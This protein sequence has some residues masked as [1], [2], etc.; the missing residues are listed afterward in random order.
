MLWED[1]AA[2]RHPSDGGGRAW[3][4]SVIPDEGP[5]AL[6]AGGRARFELVYQAGPLG[7]LEGGAVFLQTSP[8]WGWDTPQTAFPDAP[9]YTTVQSDAPGIELEAYTLAS[10]LLGIFV[11]G[12]KLEAGEQI[13]ITFGA[14][15]AMAQVDR[16]AEREARIWFAVDGDGDGVRRLVEDSPRIDIATAAP[17]RLLLTL[18]STVR[19]GEPFRLSVAVTDWV[20]NADIPFEGEVRLEMPEG[21]ELP[22]VIELRPEDAGSRSVEGVVRSEGIFA[23]VGRSG[24]LSAESNPMLASASAPRILWADLHGHSQLSDGTGTPEDYFR[25]ARDVAALDVVALTDH[26]HWGIRFLDE[27]PDLWEQIRSTAQRF[28][29]PGR[30]VTLLGYEWTSWVH[31]HRH[32]LYFRD[33]GEVFSTMDPDTATPA[34]LW[35][36][37]AGRPA[38]TFA[39]HSAG[40]PIGT[41]WAYRPD[42]EIE[43]VTEVISVH[44]SSEAMD[45][46]D[47]IY[48]PVEGNFVRDVLDAGLRFGFIGSGDSHDGHPGLSQL[49][50]GRGGLAAIFSEDATR[51]GVL[52]ALRAR[53]CYATN[54]PRIWLRFAL[55]GRPMGS[56]LSVTSSPTQE[57]DVVAIATAPIE[58]IDLVRSGAEVESLEGEGRRVWSEQIE[59]PRLE[60]GEYLYLRVLQEDGGAAWSSPIYA[61]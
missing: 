56:M 24:D 3:I 50:S 34:G 31:G 49:A 21:V 58:R 33:E 40:G 41:D 10:Q 7:V 6:R 59:I 30:F 23:V 53:R 13:L 46:P 4:T 28:H 17:E 52:A 57:I 55:D 61:E 43:P 9:G 37:L 36:A 25:Y 14:G 22:E 20:G 35:A 12:R 38:L 18:P 60:R 45:S 47:R 2:P 1:L 51:E 8:F 48:D 44:G 32:V 26:D 29:Q 15:P 5:G 16:Y 54:G 11:R 39:H 27:R 19:P 42:P